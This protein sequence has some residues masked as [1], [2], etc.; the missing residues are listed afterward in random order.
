M[1]CVIVSDIHFGV[2]DNELVKKKLNR[3]VQFSSNNS[4]LLICLG[5][6]IGSDK[7]Q[8]IGQE[9]EDKQNI[10]TVMDIMD[11]FNGTI[12]YM[13]GNHDQYNINKETLYEEFG[14][15]GDELYDN[16][17][18]LDTSFHKRVC[19]KLNLDH[20]DSLSPND[21]EII[22]SHH[23]YIKH[24]VEN[25]NW[26][27]KNPEMAYCVNRKWGLEIIKNLNPSLMI[28]AHLHQR[29]L[30]NTKI[31]PAYTLG[32]FNRKH[33]ESTEPHGHFTHL[34][35]D[36]ITAHRITNELDVEKVLEINY[37][38]MFY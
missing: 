19:G 37:E 12:K 26:F 22:M 23:P 25:N 1:N 35:N 11:I 2:G 5:D 33:P 17:V 16:T 21:V 4:N 9:K 13:P 24:S 14:Y 15:S 8:Q 31:C 36:K 7:N 18:L 20:L 6:L 3:L 32:P 30:L 29:R 28:N 34:S 38:K 10:K 27:N